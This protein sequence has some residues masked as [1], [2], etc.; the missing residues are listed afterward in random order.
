MRVKRRENSGA[1]EFHCS[2]SCSVVG[3]GLSIFFSALVVFSSLFFCGHIDR[4]T[5]YWLTS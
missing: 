5:P 2:L 1:N 4:F 3:G